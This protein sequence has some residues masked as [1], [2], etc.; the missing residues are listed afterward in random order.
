MKFTLDWAET[1]S[2]KV[3]SGAPLSLIGPILRSSGEVVS[4]SSYIGDSLAELP[5]FTEVSAGVPG[6]EA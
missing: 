2:R 5:A 3:D 4:A 1:T 6:A